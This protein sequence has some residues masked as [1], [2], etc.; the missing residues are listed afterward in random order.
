MVQDYKLTTRQTLSSI[1]SAFIFGVLLFLP[2]LLR[3][4]STSDWVGTIT[5]SPGIAIYCI[6][7]FC[8]VFVLDRYFLGIFG[9]PIRRKQT[10]EVSRKRLF[11]VLF[12]V[13]L[14]VIVG[15]ILLV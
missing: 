11:L 14:I 13:P 15:I 2:D 3:K 12:I 8:G 6:L 1:V 5:N 7:L 9:G 4:F 10:I